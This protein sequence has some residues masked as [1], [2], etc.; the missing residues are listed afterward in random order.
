VSHHDSR[1]LGVLRIRP[2]LTP[3]AAAGLSILT[4]GGTVITVIGGQVAVALIPLIVCVLA[5]TV[6]DGGRRISP[7]AAA[8][9]SC[10]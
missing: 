7:L 1:G 6:A 10:R 2:G 4:A 9:I 8:L 5:A 3:L